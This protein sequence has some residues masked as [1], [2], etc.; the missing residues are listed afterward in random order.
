MPNRHTDALAIA[1]GACNPLAITNSIARGLNEIREQP[2]GWS[3]AQ[4]TS[5]PAI[6]L[7][8]SQLAYITGIWG[9]VSNF[10]KGDDFR[11]CEQACVTMSEWVKAAHDHNQRMAAVHD[12]H[13][14][15][16]VVSIDTIDPEDE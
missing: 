7:M 8:V 16:N 5:D 2:G 15:N 10:A 13:R 6:R 4:M 9:G 1:A 14:T 12:S 3:T 11:Q